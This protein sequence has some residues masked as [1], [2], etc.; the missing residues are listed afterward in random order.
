MFPEQRNKKVGIAGAILS[1]I[2]LGL[3]IATALPSTAYP[4]NPCPGIYYE[5][6]FNSTRLVPQGCPL[7]EATRQELQRQNLNRDRESYITPPYTPENQRSAIPT[8]YPAEGAREFLGALAPENNTVT[9]Q[10]ENTTNVPITYRATGQTDWRTLMP[11]AQETLSGLPLPITITMDRNDDGFIAVTPNFIDESTV[12][13]SFD[14]AINRAE[15]KRAMRIQ[16]DGQVY[17]H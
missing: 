3:P 17:V 10:F 4:L 7:N 6:P 16:E 8:P 13:I 2:A 9:V 1:G 12:S 15:G 5:E 14:E 11:D